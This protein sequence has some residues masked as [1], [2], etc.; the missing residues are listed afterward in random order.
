MHK[1]EIVPLRRKEFSLL[2]YLMRNPGQTLTRNMILEH[3]WDSDIDLIT[4]IVDVHLVRFRDIKK[5]FQVQYLIGSTCR[6]QDNLG[7]TVI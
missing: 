1:S 5:E 6:Y 4:N 2:E 7:K 3:V